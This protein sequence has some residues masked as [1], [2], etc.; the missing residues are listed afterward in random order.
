MSEGDCGCQG[1]CH[2][3]GE[4]RGAR[5]ADGASEMGRREFVTIAGAGGAAI[6]F[7]AAA[8]PVVAGPFGRQDVIDHFVPADKKLTREW[9]E[10]LFA[11]GESTW[12]TGEDLRTIG[13]PVGGICAGQVYLT[14]DGRLTCWDIFNQNQ[15]TGYGAVNYQVGRAAESTVDGGK[16]VPVTP[17]DQGFAV[18]IRSGG[19]TVDRTLDRDGFPGAR[20]CGE[21]PIGYVEYADR[22]LPVEIRLEAFSP[23]VPLNAADSALPATV[24]RYTV[25]NTSTGPVELTLAG[26]LEN[27]VARHTGPARA[28]RLE[29]R[30][31]ALR[32]DGFTAMLATVHERPVPS[33]PERPPVVFADFES[34]GYGNWT[35]E[36]E[37]FGGGPARGTLPDQNPVSGFEGQGLVNTFLGGDALTGALRSPTFTIERPFVAFLIGGGSHQRTCVNLIVDGAVV[38]TAS[39]RDNERLEPYNWDVRDLLGQTA[40]IEIL[41]AES[42]G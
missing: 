23:F 16:V 37:A 9:I 25:R 6:A 31:T 32:S 39:G 2:G 7:M 10:A 22:S 26:W 24:M 4:D 3:G 38:R 34:A 11:R 33:A 8:L 13:M 27:A 21:Y 42:S 19:R 5:G 18:R 15:N 29:R 41:D 20:F 14:G 36:G 28:T 30:N 40:R 1:R 35:V 17:L 12:Y